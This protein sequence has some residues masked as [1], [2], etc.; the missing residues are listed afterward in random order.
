MWV[1]AHQPQSETMIGRG[2]ELGELERILSGARR[3]R[4]RAVLVL[5]EEGIGKSALAAEVADRAL[6][7]GLRVST[8]RGSVV[9][10][11]VP[12][13][14]IAEAVAGFSRTAGLRRC[15]ELGPYR[16][17][18]GFLVPDFAAGEGTADVPSP[19]V[20][21][22]AVLRLAA[23]AGRD[24]G[25]LLI[26]EDLQDADLQAHAVVEYLADNIGR[27]PT[28]LLATLRPEPRAALDLVHALAQRDSA[29]LVEL[30]RLGEDEL[31]EL[32]ASWL[33]VPASEVSHQVASL[34]WRDSGGNPLI[35]GELLREMLG[36]GALVRCGSGFFLA[37]QVPAMVP[38]VLIRS[39]GRLADRL[40]PHGR[41]LFTAAAAFGRRFPLSVV[42]AVAGLSEDDLL[43]HLD[44]G[45]AAGLVTPSGPGWY[46][47]A[48]PLAAEALLRQLVPA[49][50]AS[51]ASRA[52][53]AVN[54]LYPGL[55][56]EW[57]E[58]AACLRQDAGELT[59][60]ARLFATAG[61]R[62]LDAGTPGPAASLLDRAWHLLTGSA[63]GTEPAEWAALRGGVFDSL[64]DA[65]AETGEDDRV[66]QLGQWFDEL[67]DGLVDRSRLA[68]HRVRLGWAAVAI[69]QQPEGVRQLRAARAL[70]GADTTDVLTAPADMRAVPADALAASADALAAR[71]ALSQNGARNEDG[72]PGE[73]DEP[74]RARAAS[75]ARRAVAAAALAGPPDTECQGWLVLGE[76]ARGHDAAEATACFERAHVLATGHGLPLL[77]LRAAAGLGFGRWLASADVSGLEQVRRMALRLGAVTAGRDI[78]ASLA[79]AWALSGRYQDA[80]ELIGRFPAD[81]TADMGA[82]TRQHVLLAAATLAAHQGRRRAMADAL[83]EF[84]RAGGGQSDLAPLASGLAEAFCALAEEDADLARRCVEQAVAAGPGYYPL[85]GGH[86]LHLLLSVL[87]GA[88]GWPLHD[89]ISGDPAAGLRWNRQ[90]IVFARAVLLGREGRSAQAQATVTEAEYLAAP[91]PATLHLGLRLV[92]EAAVAAGWGDPV[93]WLRRAEKHFHAASLPAPASACRA[94]LRRLGAT[95]P[96]RRYDSGRVP[97]E[98]RVRGVTLREYEVLELL[99][100]RPG[101]KEIASRL[102]ISPR[103]VE[104]HVASLM[105]K[106]GLPDRLALCG[107][108]AAVSQAVG[109]P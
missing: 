7:A 57:C 62:A 89:K 42:Q 64:L 1:A 32:A 56:G 105:T 47:F 33:R 103:T 78:D 58:R 77:R 53:S 14:P 76:L 3:H 59:A 79:I 80:A 31:A 19:V 86:G 82:G 90:F 20:V 29:M 107:L 49:S 68:A 66:R 74:G 43:A 12:F 71:L 9:G 84:R 55:P 65:L 37:G 23:A 50:R 22:E 4:G 18:L 109:L 63:D 40:G 92:A 75:L 94:I 27:Q 30:G 93:D 99:A 101:N 83:T 61:N 96:Q 25:C 5:G 106:A 104:K 108:A 39:V 97:Q 35:A 6:A 21:G 41:A 88:E 81:E 44:A 54:A 100:A 36:N 13:R 67:A 73:P 10:P 48:Q 8:G 51:L 91:F 87:A 70:L 98:L 95:V 11:A 15:E 34:L 60:A 45:A 85:A 2:A 24:G 102:H 72:E 46:A 28:A 69:G 52:A 26:L 17:V 38:H 16:D